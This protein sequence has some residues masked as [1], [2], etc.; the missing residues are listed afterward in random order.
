M[1][2]AEQKNGRQRNGI[3]SRSVLLRKLL[4][5]ESLGR[6]K[7]PG[8]YRRK[9]R[10]SHDVKEVWGIGQQHVRSLC[11]NISVW[12]LNLWLF[13]L[14]ELWAWNQMARQL[15]HRSGSP[16]DAPDRRPSH[17]DRRKDVSD[18]SQSSR[19]IPCAV[20]R[21]PRQMSLSRTAHGVC[22][23]LLSET[24][25]KPRKR[26][27]CRTICRTPPT[28]CHAHHENPNPPAMTTPTRRVEPTTD[29]KCSFP[30]ATSDRWRAA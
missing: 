13:T 1:I 3:S 17:V 16:L 19:H 4:P 25:A 14:L 12:H 8:Q 7:R 23:L 6:M 5:S 26:S 15:S 2:G 27:V 11:T 30:I 24:P 29:R 20:G 10:V 28:T 9:H 18:R 22:L 21:I